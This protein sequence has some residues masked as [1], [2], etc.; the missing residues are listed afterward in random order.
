MR[1]PAIESGACLAAG[2]RYALRPSPDRVASRMQPTLFQQA[3]GAPF[4]RLPESLRRLHGVRGRARYAGVATFERGRNPLARLCARIA[5]LPP[6]VGEVPVAVEVVADARGESWHRDFG[7]RRM[8]TRLALKDGLLRERLGMLQFRHA[9]HA[10]DGSIWWTVAGVRLFGFVPLPASLFDGVRCREYQ[11][12]D[13]YRFEVEASLPV[14]G[15]V[16][17]YAGWLEPA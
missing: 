9:L 13:R 7:G 17:R 2:R 10:N 11:Q 12:D 6:L 1:P 15:R 3:L 5:G 4:F 14:A 8:S 16:V